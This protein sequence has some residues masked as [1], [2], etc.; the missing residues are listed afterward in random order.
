MSF[1]PPSYYEA[2]GVRNDS[3]PPAFLVWDNVA[4]GWKCEIP[5]E[6]GSSI[7]DWAKKYLRERGNRVR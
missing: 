5:P 7:L 4:G 2:V 3:N 6:I 1:C